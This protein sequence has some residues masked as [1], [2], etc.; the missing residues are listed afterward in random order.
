MSFANANIRGNTVHR[1]KQTLAKVH[2]IKLI[3]YADYTLEGPKF[4]VTS[5]NYKPFAIYYEFTQYP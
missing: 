1:F 4:A 5:F 2:C 3:C